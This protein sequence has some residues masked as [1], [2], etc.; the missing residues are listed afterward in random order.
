ML[1]APDYTSEM[2]PL[3]VGP[4]GT[5]ESIP[6]SA[7]VRSELS[8]IAAGTFAPT[9]IP[10]AFEFPAKPQ[11]TGTAEDEAIWA[12]TLARAR[13]A[14]EAQALQAINSELAAKFGVDAWKSHVTQLDS[15]QSVAR[16]R[17]QELQAQITATNAARKATQEGQST[18]LRAL[19]KRAAETAENNFAVASACDDASREVKRLRLI[20]DKAGL[21]VSDVA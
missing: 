11:V 13:V 16:L 17:V 9:V 5:F 15:L 18:R 2:P 7:A 14:V 19:T 20:A 12:A 4:D 8:R 6:S 10:S 3:P 1:A 21:G